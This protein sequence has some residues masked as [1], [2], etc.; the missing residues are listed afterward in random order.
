MRE[1]EIETL[2]ES[3]A[4]VGV[5]VIESKAHRL[6]YFNK[7]AEEAV[8]GIYLGMTC[9]SLWK[10]ECVLCPFEIIGEK[11]S[12]H[13]IH[14]NSPFGKVVDI[15]ANKMLWHGI[16]AVTILVIPHK[17]SIEEEWIQ[18]VGKMYA[19]SLVTVFGECM[20]VNLTEDYFM[21]CQEDMLWETIAKDGGFSETNKRYVK[22]VIHPDDRELFSRYYTSE[23]MIKAFQKGRKK[24]TK[25]MRRLVDDDTYHMVELTAARIP[26]YSE[27]EY[28]AVLVYSDINEEYLQEQRMNVEMEQLATAAKDAYELLVAV[29]LTQ[30]TYSI[31]EYERFLLYDVPK[32]GKFDVL[33]ATEADLVHPTQKEEFTKK[34]SRENLLKKY[35]SGE[36]QV[37]M[38]IRQKAEDGRYHWYLVQAVRVQNHYTDDILEMTMAKNI[39]EDRRQQEL[40]LEKE[41]KS[42]ELLKEALKKAEEANKAK[43]RFLS[44]MSHD[45]RT[46]MNAI[47]GMTTLAK[48]NFDNPDKLKEYLDKIE[49]S[50]QHLL[51]LINEVLDVSKIESG[52]QELDESEQDLEELLQE[53]VLIVRP[54]AQKKEQTIRVDIDS[55]MHKIVTVD[56]GKLKQVLVNVIE[57]ASKYTG[58]NGQISV[59]LDEMDREEKEYGT[60]RIIVEDNGIGMKKEFIEH[61]FE[62]F[63]RENDFRTSKITGTGLGMTIVQNIIKMMGGKIE[64]QSE[65]GKGSRFIITVRLLKKDKVKT[66]LSEEGQE[67]EEFAGVHILLAEDNELNQQIAEEMFEF[68][69]A[70]VDTVNNGKEAVEAVM[71]REPLYYD[72]VFMDIQMPVMD[73]YEAA[74]AIRKSGKAHIDELP[75]VAMTA[76]AFAED[77]KKTKLAGMNAHMSKPIDMNQIKFILNRCSQWKKY[78]DR[79]RGV[80]DE[81]KS[82]NN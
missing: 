6:L 59:S 7:R 4:E 9:D 15:V 40:E 12:S 81:T 60:Y 49:I 2:L 38:E 34:F 37:S 82:D 69:G 53:A 31:V 79:E 5:Y 76:N 72:I 41:R 25:K 19:E 68:L 24:I 33:N 63:S 18:K 65:Y 16:P 57:N 29:N 27:E 11:E 73:G 36:K 43:S 70:Q 48:L 61:I 45:I 80:A 78:N 13:V 32:E 58:N 50:S 22:A 42:S 39:D 46:P 30:N 56:A 62:P 64:V 77:I 54:L 75:I 74:E 3:L 17:F 1:N 28:W 14:Y 55:G 47:V 21:N 67:K 51:S 66:L 20:I 52:K 8:P 35:E 71:S 26:G 23:A 10:K 44:S